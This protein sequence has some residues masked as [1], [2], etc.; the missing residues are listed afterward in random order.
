[1]AEIVLHQWEISPFCGKVRKILRHKGLR[2]R[3]VNYNG[4]KALQVRKL[5]PVGKLP[6]LDY[7]GERIA[8]SSRIAEFIEVRHPEPELLPA[9]PQARALAQLWEDWADESLFWF[10]IHYRVNDADALNLAGESICA[11]RPAWERALI[12]PLIRRDYRARLHAQG[13]GRL[14]M[15]EVD[16]LFNAH[17]DR[18][19][20]V[21]TGGSRLVANATSIADIAVAAQL[22]EINRTSARRDWIAARPNIVRWLAALADDRIGELQTSAV[23]QGV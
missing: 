3:T 12:M 16:R 15:P 4:L 23:G 21:L 20:M 18:I 13:L 5:G 11:G 10:E 8:D 7:D 6:V 2:F 17:L 19:E 1:M 14:P 9:D 22:D